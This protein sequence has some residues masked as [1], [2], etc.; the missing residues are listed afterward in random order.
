MKI[1]HKGTILKQ[2]ESNIYFINIEHKLARQSLEGKNIGYVQ[3]YT[4]IMEGLGIFSTR[5]S[6]K[7]PKPNFQQKPAP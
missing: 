4:T 7:I 2:F 1:F 6:L 3:I 5:V